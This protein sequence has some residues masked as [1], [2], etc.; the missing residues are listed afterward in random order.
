VNDNVRAFV[1]KNHFRFSFIPQA[2]RLYAIIAIQ[3]DKIAVVYRIAYFL[4]SYF[5]QQCVTKSICLRIK[6]RMIKV[7][8]DVLT[9]YYLHFVRGYKLVF[10][11]M[12][13]DKN[14]NKFH[15]NATL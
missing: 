15:L 5:T 12:T 2:H 3:L 10:L 9:A 8:I 13:I 11:I 14:R 6:Y 1:R 7:V 4:S